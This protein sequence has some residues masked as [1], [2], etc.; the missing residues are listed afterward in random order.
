MAGNYRIYYH[1]S[2][3]EHSIDQWLNAD[4]STIKDEDVI[5]AVMNVVPSGA[6]PSI[7]RL[8]SLGED[9]KPALYDEFLIVGSNGQIYGLIFEK[10]GCDGWFYLPDYRDYERRPGQ[11]ISNDSF[12][13][14][15]AAGYILSNK[16]E[17]PASATL[18]WDRLSVLCNGEEFYL[19]PWSPSPH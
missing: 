2:G 8:I 1:H 4:N 18:D 16:D 7:L 3:K 14:P 9:G 11:H 6:A 15:G 13:I 19:V 10:I 17:F 12:V 5:K